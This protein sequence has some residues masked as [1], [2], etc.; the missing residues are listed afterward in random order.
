[1]SFSS[2]TNEHGYTYFL[3]F[4]TPNSNYNSMYVSK[5]EKTINEF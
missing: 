3:L 5:F 1:M 2:V 4:E